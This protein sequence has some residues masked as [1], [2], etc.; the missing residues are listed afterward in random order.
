MNHHR[1]KRNDFRLADSRTVTIESWI[2]GPTANVAAF[3]TDGHQIS[4][5]TYQAHVDN[6]DLF[7]PEAQASMIDSLAAQLEY[8]LINNP[9][10]HIRKR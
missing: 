2:H 4:V 9:G 8:D 6:P 5:A 7:T 1:T 3:G 10:L